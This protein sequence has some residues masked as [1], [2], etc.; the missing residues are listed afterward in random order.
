MGDWS[1]VCGVF[2]NNETFASQHFVQVSFNVN[3]ALATSKQEYFSNLKTSLEKGNVKF[4]Q[5]IAPKQDFKG[6]VS[7]TRIVPIVTERAY[8]DLISDQVYKTNTTRY[9]LACPSEISYSLDQS[10]LTKVTD[11]IQ[12]TNSKVYSEPRPSP[13]LYIFNLTFLAINDYDKTVQGSSYPNTLIQRRLN[14][15]LDKAYVSKVTLSKVTLEGT[16]SSTKIPIVKCIHVELEIRSIAGS[17]ENPLEPLLGKEWPSIVADNTTLIIPEQIYNLSGGSPQLRVPPV[18][19]ELSF[20][21]IDNKE[22]LAGDDRLASSFVQQLSTILSLPRTCFRQ[23]R[24]Q[25]GDYL[26][27]SC[28]ITS[29]CQ[30]GVVEIGNANATFW[31]LLNADQLIIR[32]GDQGGLLAGLVPSCQITLVLYILAKSAP[33]NKNVGLLLEKR[34]PDIVVLNIQNYFVQLSDFIILNVTMNAWRT[35]IATTMPCSYREKIIGTMRTDKWT[36]GT[37]W[38]DMSFEL[39]DG[40]TMTI[41]DQYYVRGDTGCRIY[42]YGPNTIS[43]VVNRPRERVRFNLTSDFQISETDKFLV[44]LIDKRFATADSNFSSFFNNSGQGKGSPPSKY[45]LQ[46]DWYNLFILTDP[47]SALKGSSGIRNISD[48]TSAIIR[49]YT[50]Y[51]NISEKAFLPGSKVSGINYL[52]IYN[53]ELIPAMLTDVIQVSFAVANVTGIQEFDRP[54]HGDTIFRYNNET[55][56]APLQ[57]ANGSVVYL[58]H[59]RTIEI[60][61]ACPLTNLPR[62]NITLFVDE[63]KKQLTKWTNIPPDFFMD[64]EIGPWTINT[65]STQFRLN[66][67]NQFRNQTI[68]LDSLYGN[69]TV[70]LNTNKMAVLD[71][72]ILPLKNHTFIII[73]RYDETYLKTVPGIAA[74]VILVLTVCYMDIKFRIKSWIKKRAAKR[75]AVSPQSQAE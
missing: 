19:Q 47:R 33:T 59:I 14:R 22:Y 61:I 71:E 53:G 37:K 42:T 21:L 49:Q 62:N 10:L 38:T 11:S 26:T 8:Y 27:F 64:H 74:T 16:Y 36:V 75:N 1:V 41:P 68:D 12:M 60:L 56:Y 18:M 46:I 40:T 15:F 55:L 9:T 29:V 4:K 17:D 72:Y 70:Q 69:F 32:H 7:V 73:G 57:F 45:A 25:R 44:A 31:H 5:T 50:Q 58:P 23:P 34:F 65:R 3:S 54:L 2:Y 6:Q 63:F 43:P 35:N 52:G 13:S 66:A 20:Q 24:L 67:T 48:F 30:D 28:N 39:A 51:Y